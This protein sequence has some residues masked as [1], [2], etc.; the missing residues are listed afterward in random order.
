M[1]EAFSKGSISGEW[2]EGGQGVDKGAMGNHMKSDLRKEF[3]WASENSSGLEQPAYCLV[4]AFVIKVDD[5]ISNTLCHT[6][7]V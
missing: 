3:F 7:S 6:I 5:L 4:K 1:L 2:G